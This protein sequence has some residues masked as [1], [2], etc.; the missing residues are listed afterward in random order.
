MRP[1]D[2]DEVT[3]D[4]ASFKYSKE[5]GE[6]EE[7]YNRA[8][9]DCIGEIKAIPALY[10]E[11]L[12]EE[13]VKHGKWLPDRTGNVYWVCSNCGFPSEA[14]GAFK[15]YKYCPN[16]GAKMDGGDTSERQAMAV[17]SQND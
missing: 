14:S 5:Y 15:L 4:L 12:D 7:V 10:A 16:C 9:D 1:I 8:I 2:A 3:R 6:E 17:Q 13:Q 11:A